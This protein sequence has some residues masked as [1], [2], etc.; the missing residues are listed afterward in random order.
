MSV[1]VNVKYIYWGE[2]SKMVN[3]S[4]ESLLVNDGEALT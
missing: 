4:T 3:Y 2:N 1:L